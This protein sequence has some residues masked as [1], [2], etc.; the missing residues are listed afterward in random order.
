M[1]TPQKPPTL[2]ALSWFQNQRS[3]GI[4]SWSKSSRWAK[5]WTTP[6]VLLPVARPIA[7]ASS[8][9]GLWAYSKYVPGLC[10]ISR[11]SASRMRSGIVKML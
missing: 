7:A 8:E 4:P 11:V 9:T 10:A 3:A 1:F 6:G 2:P 5:D